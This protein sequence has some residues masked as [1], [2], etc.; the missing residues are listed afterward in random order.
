MLAI[1]A[2]GVTSA[3]V[4][5]QSV[6]VSAI[7]ERSAPR[8][9]AQL[10]QPQSASPLLAPVNFQK[11]ATQEHATKTTQLQPALAARRGQGFGLMIAGGALFVAGLL[12]GGSA[13]TVMDL[14]GAGIGAYG[15]YL[16]F[17]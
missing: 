1:T 14:A 2:L 9:P 15:L 13:G 7:S 3:S 16:Y 4:S 8:T 11:E 12:T 5:A 17:R 10:L 6:G